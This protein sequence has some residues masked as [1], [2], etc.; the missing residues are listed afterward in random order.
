MDDSRFRFRETLSWR[1]GGKQAVPSTFVT[2]L[3]DNNVI[4]PFSGQL[5]WILDTKNPILFD[6][7]TK[8]H[9]EVSI[10][11]S[12]MADDVPAI[13]A[14]AWGVGVPFE[15]GLRPGR[16]FLESGASTRTA[17]QAST[18]FFV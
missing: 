17:R 7:L 12:T 3:E 4:D 10:L 5:E 18:R 13:L 8:F 14:V 9:V 15:Y 11:V 6:S 2:E 1:K 16:P